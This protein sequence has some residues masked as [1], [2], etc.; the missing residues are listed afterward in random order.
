M[1]NYGIGYGRGYYPRGYMAA[2]IGYPYG[3]L[4][5]PFWGYGYPYFGGLGYYNYPY[6][7]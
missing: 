1:Y 2:G 5:M 6:Y 4:A 3:A 7:L